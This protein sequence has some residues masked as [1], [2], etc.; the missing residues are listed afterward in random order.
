[1]CVCVSDEAGVR[2]D[3]LPVRSSGSVSPLGCFSGTLANIVLET[4]VEEN[5]LVAVKSHRPTCQDV[6]RVFSL[7]V[8]RFPHLMSLTLC[9]K[10]RSLD[11]G[12]ELGGGPWAGV[13][14]PFLSPLSGPEGAH[15]PTLTVT[16]SQGNE[17]EETLR[18]FLSCLLLILPSLLSF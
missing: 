15:L 13:A 17:R 4:K 18:S 12:T 5:S 2:E 14:V 7:P 8:P 9:E 16:P 1:M 11:R 6:G 10:K 3:N